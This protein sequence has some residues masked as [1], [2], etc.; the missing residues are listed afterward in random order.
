[1]QSDRGLL[2]TLDGW[3]S[4]SASPGT[5]LGTI[6]FAQISLAFYFGTIALM[7]M[8][9]AVLAES[10]WEVL[11]LA[12][13]GIT[14]A[15]VISDKRKLTNGL[16]LVGVGIAWWGAY[17]EMD[18]AVAMDDTGMNAATVMLAAGIMIYLPVTALALRA[19]QAVRILIAPM[20][21]AGSV[22]CAAFLAIGVIAIFVFT[23]CKA[24]DALIATLL[25]S[26]V[27]IPIVVGAATFFILVVMAIVNW[28][29]N[30]K[31]AATQSANE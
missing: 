3:W 30:R 5:N 8:A 17:I 22:T 26:A 29:K 27:A 23:G 18:R 4:N 20:L 6:Q 10:R 9:S 28:R 11:T 15:S 21:V 7:A 16:A 19:H 12:G 2:K 24:G 14:A 13:V 1:M 25:W 31:G